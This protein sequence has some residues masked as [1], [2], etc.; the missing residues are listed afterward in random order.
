MI[1]NLSIILSDLERVVGGGLKFLKFTKLNYRKE[2][3]DPLPPPPPENVLDPRMVLILSICS[4][5]A[6][7]ENTLA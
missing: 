6:V 1:F 4:T 2:I 7:L 5:T 3:S